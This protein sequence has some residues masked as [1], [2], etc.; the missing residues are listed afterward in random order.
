MLPMRDSG[1]YGARLSRATRHSALMYILGV[2]SLVALILTGCTQ[3]TTTQPGPYYPNLGAPAS[4]TATLAPAGY[5]VAAWPANSEPSASFTNTVYVAFRDAGKPISSAQVTL[6]AQSGTA[7]QS[8][9]PRETSTSGYA[10]FKLSGLAE[11]PNQP[12]LV[13]ITV[14]Y[15]GQNFTATTDFTPAP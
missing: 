7:A 6:Y 3:F 15:Q 8:Y 12:V 14:I 2:A 11:R 5:T 1:I 10:A 4:P 9:G 13:H